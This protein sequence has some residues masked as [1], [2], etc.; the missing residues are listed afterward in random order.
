MS[1]AVILEPE[2]ERDLSSLPPVLQQL[3]EISL[4][5]LASDPVHL[6]RPT[7]FP[8]IQAQMYRAELEFE[9]SRYIAIIIFRYS[10]DE[11][12]LHVLQIA[13]LIVE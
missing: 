10:Q 1:Y 3:V 4:R 6:S 5:Q 8:Y 7:H 12:T 9:Q 2:A 13:H 11:T